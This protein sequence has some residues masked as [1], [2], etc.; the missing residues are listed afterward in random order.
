MGREAHELWGACIYQGSGGEWFKGERNGGI[1][2]LGFGRAM[3]HN[4]EKIGK[5]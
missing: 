2:S 1:I 5:M 3:N 4:S